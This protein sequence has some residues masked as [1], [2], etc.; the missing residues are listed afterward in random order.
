MKN[1]WGKWIWKYLLYI[2][3][4]TSVTIISQSNIHGKPNPHIKIMICKK[5]SVSVEAHIL[6][7]KIRLFEKFFSS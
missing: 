2:Y 3:A 5:G 1:A 7:I 6:A 4:S